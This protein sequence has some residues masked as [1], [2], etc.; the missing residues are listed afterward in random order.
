VTIWVPPYRFIQAIQRTLKVVRFADHRVAL[1]RDQ[2]DFVFAHR[3]RLLRNKQQHNRMRPVTID[4]GE[5][6]IALNRTARWR[7]LAT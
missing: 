3:G 6:Q 1:L 7:Q 5:F 4:D 2:F